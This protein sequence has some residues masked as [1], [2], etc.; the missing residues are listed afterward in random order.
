MPLTDNPYEVGY[1]AGMLDGE[2]SISL[3][4]SYAKRTGGRYVYPLVRISNTDP[5]VI[6]W[7]ARIGVGSKV[8]TY[9]HEG[10]KE[11][12][13]VA[14]AC[15]EAI[16][17][18]RWIEP[19]LIVKRD[20]ARLVLDLCDLNEKAREEA[21]GYFGNGHPIPDWLVAEREMAFERLQQLNARG[22]QLCL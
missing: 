15:G 21:G 16:V 2:G 4:R 8:H 3:V 20:R 14:W 22:V 17:I 7:L 6:N 10:R 5:A 11:V 1:F 9:R 19:Y 13:H 18:L 12:A